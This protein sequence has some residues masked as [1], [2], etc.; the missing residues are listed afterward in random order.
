MQPLRKKIYEESLKFAL[1]DIDSQISDINEGGELR[2]V[3]HAPSMINA[4]Q[5]W[6]HNTFKAGQRKYHSLNMC[7]LFNQYKI[8][9]IGEEV[10]G[11]PGIG[12]AEGMACGSV[13][14]GLDDNMYK[15][16]GMIPNKHYLAFKG[17]Y[18]ELQKAIAE[19]LDNFENL[20]SISE[21]GYKFAKNNFR[22]DVVFENFLSQ[23]N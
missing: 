17:G 20:N 14:V 15:D 19:A 11:L 1:I 16:L 6:F 21:N 3:R 5:N 4:L 22:S 12:F 9:I 10:V 7:D 23:L 18:N 2:S 8:H 13:F